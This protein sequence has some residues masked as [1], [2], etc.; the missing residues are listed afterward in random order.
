VIE[1]Y[2][3]LDNIDFVSNEQLDEVLEEKDLTPVQEAQVVAI[4]VEA[5]IQALKLSLLILA[6]IAV[7]AIIPAGGLPDYK[8]KEVPVEIAH[9][10]ESLEESIA[11]S[12]E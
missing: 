7:L 5:R 8:P 12:A 4:N 11:A 10:I 3:D 1:E 2:V 9:D 6:G